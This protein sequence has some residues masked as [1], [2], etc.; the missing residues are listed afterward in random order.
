MVGI[1]TICLAVSLSSEG[2]QPV[3]I[4]HVKV[5]GQTVGCTEHLTDMPAYV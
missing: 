5:N 3:Y 1:N 2:A 4:L